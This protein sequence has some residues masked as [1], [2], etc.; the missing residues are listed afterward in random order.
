MDEI[1]IKGTVSDI[2]YESIIFSFRQGFVIYSLIL[3]KLKYNFQT[4]GSFEIW[5]KLFS[6]DENLQ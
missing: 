6:C 3:P 1:N 2:L 5:Q 4:A